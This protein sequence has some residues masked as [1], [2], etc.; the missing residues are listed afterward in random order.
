MH[1]P[2]E[3]VEFFESLTTVSIGLVLVRGVHRLPQ[4]TGQIGVERRFADVGPSSLVDSIDSF[5]AAD[6]Q[7][8]DVR[9]VDGD[10]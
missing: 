2:D 4:L 8:D 6:D 10:L 7:H 1:S 5:L 9:P 3:A